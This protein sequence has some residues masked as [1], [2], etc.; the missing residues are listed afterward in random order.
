MT[1]TLTWDT[2]VSTFIEAGL[3]RGVLYDQNGVGYA[4]SGLVSVSEQQEGAEVSPLY[5]DGVKYADAQ[6][7]GDWSG[8]IKAYT[9][10][11]EFLQFEG[12]QEVDNGLF[13]TNQE[14]KRFGLS[15]RT[16]VYD[17][18]GNVDGYKIHII[19]NAIA[20]ASSTTYNTISKSVEANVF[21]WNITAVPAEIPG[22]R[23]TAHLIF[24]TRKMGAQVILDVEH[25]LYGDGTSPAQLPTASTLASFLGTWVIIRITDNGDGTW[26][27][28]GPDSM[29]YLDTAT[30]YVINPANETYLD[31]NTFIISDTTY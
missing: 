5:Y 7:I 19:Y 29:T 26:T 2:T 30:T 18:E 16:T 6:T 21:E 27:A 24:D 22:Y 9:Y 8:S 13:V 17:S 3:D 10:P 14:Q 12:T 15:Y 11:D 31:A 20:A 25:A 1:T 28:V 23:P 4:W